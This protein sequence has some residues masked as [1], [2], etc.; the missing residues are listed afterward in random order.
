MKLPSSGN[1]QP[2]TGRCMCG[3]VRYS[4]AGGPLPMSTT[5]CN[6]EDCQR[7]S[8]S[9]FSIV[10]PVRTATLHL[11][12]EPLSTFQTTGTD[13][14]ESRARRFCPRC[15]SQVLSVLAEAPEITWLKGGTLDDHSWLSPMTEVWTQSAQPWTRRLPRRP[16]LRRGPPTVALR[17]MRPFLRVWNAVAIRK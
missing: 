13:S 6:C 7:S 17:A 16:H 12:G 11:E 14:H 15:G 2:I 10:V 8:G 4:V 5:V 3:A 1:R 9:A